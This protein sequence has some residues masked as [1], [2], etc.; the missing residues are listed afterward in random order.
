MTDYLELAWAGSASALARALERLEFAL[1]AAEGGGEEAE[2]RVSASLRQGT[3]DRQR[4]PPP[5]P[6]GEAGGPETVQERPDGQERQ[7]R[8]KALPAFPP[9]MSRLEGQAQGEEGAGD[10]P[11]LAQVRQG[12]AEAA[13]TAAL[14]KEEE[15]K[16][17][18]LAWRGGGEA[19]RRVGQ[20]TGGFS[21]FGGTAGRAEA[22][23]PALDSPL[24]S[25]LP[26]GRTGGEPLDQAEQVDLAFRRDSRRYDGG[27][28]LY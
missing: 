16:T 27:F 23:P 21:A 26:G 6:P 5:V 8:T 7:R 2:E 10:L 25:G 20:G 12:E 28:S 3:Q 19:P 22:W 13:E 11:L 9:E 4:T 14:W 24:W 18:R 17:A 1:L 15:Q